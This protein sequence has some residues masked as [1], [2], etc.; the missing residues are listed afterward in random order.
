MSSR[1]WEFSDL[2][3]SRFTCPF[4]FDVLYLVRLWL[5]EWNVSQATSVSHSVTQGRGDRPRWHVTRSFVTFGLSLRRVTDVTLIEGAPT[6][7]HCVTEGDDFACE[8][9]L[10]VRKSVGILIGKIGV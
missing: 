8:T 5:W 4:S 10:C 2:G 9:A 1:G 3:F 6:P 7:A